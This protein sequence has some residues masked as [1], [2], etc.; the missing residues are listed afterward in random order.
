MLEI[1]TAPADRREGRRTAY[2][3]LERAYARHAGG[4]LPPILRTES[5][6]PF[7]PE[8]A[9]HFSLSHTR[10]MA[11]CAM[12]SRPVGVDA[13]T[14]RPVRPGVAERSLTAAELAWL[15]AADDRDLGFLTL[16]TMKEAWVKLTGRGL[17]GRPR[18]VTLDWRDGRWG[19]LGEPVRF[20]TR[21]AGGVVLTACTDLAEPACWMELPGM[22]E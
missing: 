3:L 21:V 5:G 9:F 15:Q 19:V 18:D 12:S 13:E 20:E 1:Y 6:K 17:N 10:T 14:I 16:W 4:L 11:A 22:F 2:A 7:F 8:G